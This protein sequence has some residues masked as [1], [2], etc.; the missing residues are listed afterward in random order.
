MFYAPPAVMIGLYGGHMN[1]HSV[2]YKIEHMLLPQMFYRYGLEF[3]AAML[4]DK[5]LLFRIVDS[6][7]REHEIENPY[8]SSQFTT[9]GMRITD[10]VFVLQITFPEPEEEPLCYRS[11]AIFDPEFTNRMYF[12]IEKGGAKS[13][14]LPFVCAWTEDG[15]HLNYGNCS[16]REDE[17]LTA[18]LTH[19]I[20]EFHLQ[21][22]FNPNTLS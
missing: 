2:R 5:G 3:A 14:E 18:C 17:D 4:Q 19:Y 11:Y 1:R 9:E 8:E 12:C 16:F 20:E 10:S 6:V 21:G 7:F 22:N 13:N 15:T